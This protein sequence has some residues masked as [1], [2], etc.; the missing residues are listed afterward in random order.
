MC[1]GDSCS[2][3]R[4]RSHRAEFAGLLRVVNSA[5]EV[6]PGN[7]RLLQVREKEKHSRVWDGVRHQ[8]LG[9]SSWLRTLDPKA[10]SVLRAASGPGHRGSVTWQH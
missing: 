9:D 3:C 4:P 5:H 10:T 8:P 2:P 6:P 7:F 1:Y